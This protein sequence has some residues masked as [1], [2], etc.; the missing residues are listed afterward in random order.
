METL[1]GRLHE[2]DDP[3]G[4]RLGSE[5]R[6]LV[7][8]PGG[9]E[10]PW[11]ELDDRSASL[12]RTITRWAVDGLVVLAVTVFV[13]LQLGPRNLLRDTIPTGGD[14]GAH[15]WG[16]AYLRDHL[17]PHWRLSGWAPDWYDGFPA[18]QF[19]MVVPALFILA[20]NAGLH[21]WAALLPLAAAVGSVVL[22]R[23]QPKRSWPRR[24]LY[25]LSPPPILFGVGMP[26]TVAFKLVAVAGLATLP[27]AV[28]AFG[29]LLKLPFPT[30]ALLTV[31]TLVFLFNTQPPNNTG[32]I[33]GGNVTSTLAGEFS[34]SI[35][36][37]FGVLYLG[38][39]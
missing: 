4:T 39:L 6:P 24:G 28:Y 29:R 30:P 1:P 38:L 21:G 17:L 27:L 15:V 23:R 2:A 14:M 16:P 10:P 35:S 18:Y 12:L 9:R 19:Y 13:L 25:P 26:Y 7:E 37:T 3:A 8:D 31:L 36:L 22:G 20:L 5:P 32:N 33:I 34:F 11:W